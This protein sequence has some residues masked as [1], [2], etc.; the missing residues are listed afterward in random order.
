MG[1]M[2][3]LA[4]GLAFVLLLGGCGKR[5]GVAEQTE[6]AL[7]VVQSAEED[8]YIYLRDVD[9]ASIVTLGEYKGLEVSLPAVQVEEADVEREALALLW[10]SMEV[11]A[12]IT[13]RPVAQGDTVNIDYKGLKD[14]VAFEGGTAQGARL[15]IGSG[16]FIPGFEEGLVGA[17]PGEEV[18]LDL[19]F[20][21]EY[22]SAELAGA[23]VVFE[24]K[25]NYIYP[26]EISDEAVA[27]LGAAEY[28]SRQELLDYLRA[29]MEAEQEA[30][31]AMELEATVQQALVDASAYGELPADLLAQSQE[32]VR[33]NLESQAAAYGVD[34]QTLVTWMYNM[35]LES[36]VQQVGEY[37]VKS[38][39]ALQAVAN[40]ESL[41]VSD[42][43]LEEAMEQRVQEY[44]FAS[45]EEMLGGQSKELFREDMLI[46]KSL[47]FVVAEAVVS[48][49]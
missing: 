32:Q 34:A 27:A 49:E 30:N 33:G 6:A 17:S 39:L 41:A 19:Q 42:Q 15:A 24:V 21:A 28:A 14:G 22:H 5:Q 1:K 8:G 25:V 10:D 9:L 48:Q 11:S 26:T 43:E 35:D 23:A 40:K 7:A 38:K 2:R 16:Q 12:G 3:Y 29:G 36:L 31:R 18:S 4:L 37:G 45:V 13:D 20:P 44:G 47:A 46:E